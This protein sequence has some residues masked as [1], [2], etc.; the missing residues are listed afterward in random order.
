M[1][2]NSRDP[3]RTAAH[4]IVS[5]LVAFEDGPDALSLTQ[6]AERADLPLSTAH[7]L[8]A[9]LDEAGLV[10]RTDHGTYQL[11]LRMWELGQRVGRRLRETARPYVQELHTLT[12]ET[13]QLAIRDGADVLYIERVYGPRR[14]PRASRVGGR[15]PLH[16]TAVG[17][18]ILAHEAP[19]V[20]DALLAGP[21]EPATPRTVVDPVRLR[22]QLA[23]I[24]EQGFSV[25][26][27]ETRIGACSIAVPVFHRGRI[28]AAVGLVVSSERA[29]SIRRHLPALRS[30][31]GR[32]EAATT[33][34]PLE[35]LWQATRGAAPAEPPADP[36]QDPRTR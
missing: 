15:L 7:R 5:V 2:G 17:K 10:T 22:R 23:D 26:H 35:T 4:R 32:I 36:A 24:R 6:V 21:L 25:T 8:V 30:V 16:V 27:E 13:A 31:A 11:G 1:A 14:V 19:E 18:T 28:G 20:R 29:G 33:A 12:R 34:I 3:G 9:E